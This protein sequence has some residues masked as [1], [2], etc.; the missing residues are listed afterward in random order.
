MEGKEYED[1]CDILELARDSE[2]HKRRTIVKCQKGK[3]FI[4]RDE[5]LREIIVEDIHEEEEAFGIARKLWHPDFY[6]DI[7]IDWFQGKAMR[8]WFAENRKLY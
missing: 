5:P 8:I 1:F 2:R 7:G 6:G 3:A 4:F